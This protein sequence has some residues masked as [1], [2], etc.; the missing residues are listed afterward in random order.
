MPFH[1][2]PVPGIIELLLFLYSLSIS[3][4]LLNFFLI[5]DRTEFGFS[6]SV[7]RLLQV[8]VISL[9]VFTRIPVKLNSPF[10]IKLLLFSNIFYTLFCSLFGTLTIANNTLFS[11]IDY[12]TF[13]ESFIFISSRGLIESF[14]IIFN[15]YY[16]LVIGPHLISSKKDISI[17]LRLISFVLGCSLFIG[18]FD[19]IAKAFGLNFL[20]RHIANYPDIVDIGFRFHGLFGEPRDSV[21]PLVLGLFIIFLL[22]GF[23]GMMLKFRNVMVAG[24]Y[25]VAIV[26]TFSIS[27]YLG[28]AFGFVLFLLRMIGN[29]GLKYRSALLIVLLGL[30]VVL[31]FSFTWRAQYYMDVYGFLGIYKFNITQITADELTQMFNIYPLVFYI[32]GLFEGNLISSIFGYGVGYTALLNHQYGLDGIAF[33]SSEGVRVLVERGLFGLILLVLLCYKFLS[34]FECSMPSDKFIGVFLI[35]CLF[36]LFFAHRTH[37]IWCLFLIVL[38]VYQFQLKKDDHE[39]AQCSL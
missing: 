5:F 29:G 19:L 34:A 32:Q 37:G 1:S 11:T 24:F 27:G 20:G 36:G 21:F 30:G 38:L 10:E 31:A 3:S 4:D 9:I 25:L 22:N 6:L 13:G 12:N 14:L 17:F 8:I 33:P 35:C 15:T 23:G 18:Y 28:I 39:I 26:L 2:G 16:Y 7:S